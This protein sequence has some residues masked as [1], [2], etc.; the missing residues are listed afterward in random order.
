MDCIARSLK[1][2]PTKIIRLINGR[3][4]SGDCRASAKFARFSGHH[5]VGE[6]RGVGRADARRR[7]PRRAV[8]RRAP[9]RTPRRADRRPRRRIRRT[10]RGPGGARAPRRRAASRRAVGSGRSSTG[11][12]PAGR[13]RSGA[14]PRPRAAASRTATWRPV[15]GVPWK[16]I[17]GLPSGA[18]NS[19]NASSRPSSRPRTVTARAEAIPVLPAR[20][21]YRMMGP[22]WGSRDEALRHDDPTGRRRARRPARLDPGARTAGLHRRVVG[23]GGRLRRADAAR[24]G[25]GVGAEPAARRRDPARVHARPRAAWR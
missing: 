20:G 14:R 22:R 1:R 16:P 15:P 10:A 9:A 17:T 18:P 23:R 3:T 5:P 19:A 2:R 13:A 7:S 24:A 12:S 4:R 11:R 6:A 21:I 25:V 8:A